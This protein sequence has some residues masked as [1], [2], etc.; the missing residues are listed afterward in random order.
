MCV[1][2]CVCTGGWGGGHPFELTL[3]PRLLSLV[4][5]G[6]LSLVLFHMSVVVHCPMVTLKEKPF[7]SL[8]IF[9]S[10]FISYYCCLFS[11]F[12]FFFLPGEPDS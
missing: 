9:C 12:F 5:T 10:L 11:D 7:I 6:A 4:S 1:C 2:V 3:L 8:I